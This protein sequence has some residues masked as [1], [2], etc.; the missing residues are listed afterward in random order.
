MFG[1]YNRRVER[2]LSRRAVNVID[3]KRCGRARP[4]D[5]VRLGA[6]PAAVCRERSATSVAAAVAASSARAREREWKRKRARKRARPVGSRCGGG[7][8]TAAPT[9]WV[10]FRRLAAHPIGSPQSTPHR[11]T[12]DDTDTDTA[13]PWALRTRPR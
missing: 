9:G 3:A 1:S 2:Y 7:D 6:G 10:G 11:L 5:G 13:K 12:D 8:V 4:T